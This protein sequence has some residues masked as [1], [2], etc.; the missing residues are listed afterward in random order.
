M[1]TLLTMVYYKADKTY[2]IRVQDGTG[3]LV[4]HKR[5]FKTMDGA[6]QFMHRLEQNMLKVSGSK[7]LWQDVPVK[8]Q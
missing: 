6:K 2:R 8:K 3:V 7:Q 1:S 4:E 5:T